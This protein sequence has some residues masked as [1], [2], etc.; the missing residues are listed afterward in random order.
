M[1][2]RLLIV[3]SALAMMLVNLIPAVGAESEVTENPVKVAKGAYDSYVVVIRADPLLASF[4][5]DE[6]NGRAAKAERAAFR[7]THDEAL[8]DAD[9]SIA[10]KT[11]DYTNAAN[12]FSALITHQEAERLA[13]SADVLMVMP[14]T[15]RQPTTENSP[16]FLGLTDKGGAW[17]RGYTGKGVIVGVIDTGIW[18]E[19]PSFADDGTFGTLRVPVLDESEFAACDFGNLAHNPNDAEFECNN[20]LVGAR[21]ILTTYRAILGAEYYEYDSARDDGG[22]GTHTASTAAGNAKV[23]AEVFGIDRGIVSGIA[24]EHTSSPTRPS[25][26][27]VVSGPTSQLPSTSPSPTVST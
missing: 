15:L 6:L 10:K 9:V 21:Q 18:P 19:H 23:A 17:N 26:I 24:P 4:D 8:R 3:L 1:S 20:K 25:A 13:A 11:H 14:D 2:K 12:G 27:R 7:A 22:H 16:S 5:Q